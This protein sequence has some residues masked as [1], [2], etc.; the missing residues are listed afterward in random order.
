MVYWRPTRSRLARSRTF[1]LNAAA[2]QSML[3]SSTPVRRTRATMAHQV[4]QPRMFRSPF[5]ASSSPCAPRRVPGSNWKSPPA[6]SGSRQANRRRWLVPPGLVPLPPTPAYEPVTS[7]RRTIL[8]VPE[9]HPLRFVICRRQG[10]CPE[11]NI[12]YRVCRHDDLIASDPLGRRGFFFRDV[13]SLRGV[14]SEGFVV[15]RRFIA[16]RYSDYLLP[17]RRPSSMRATGALSWEKSRSRLRPAF[18]VA[19]FTLD[20]NQGELHSLS[21][22]GAEPFKARTS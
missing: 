16:S 21:M 10:T 13:S 3:S 12:D 19:I 17:V 22:T 8:I 4:P 5:D 15:R 6:R 2:V 9:V 1:F 11:P 18:V 7:R 20:N 14:T